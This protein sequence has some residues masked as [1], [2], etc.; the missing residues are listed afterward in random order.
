M[1]NVYR[2]TLIW[3]DEAEV[4][5]A[6]SSDVYG[7]ILEHESVDLLLDRVRLA[8]PELLAFENCIS[9]DIFLDFAMLRKEKLSLNG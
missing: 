1:D 6:T 7:L 5:I 3:D 2:V 4:W 8:I 9:G